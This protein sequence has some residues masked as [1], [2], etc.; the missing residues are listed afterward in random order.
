[1]KQF[2]TREA[3][4]FGKGV[5]ERLLTGAPPSWTVTSC[6]E[7]TRLAFQEAT[8]LRQ[9]GLVEVPARQQKVV[10]Q[11]VQMLHKLCSHRDQVPQVCCNLHSSTE[12]LQE[13]CL[14]AALYMAAISKTPCTTCSS[15]WHMR[16][17]C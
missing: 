11:R 4:H 8:H 3:L 5:C 17:L 6:C 13:A 7:E 2:Y 9:E 14:D 1:M 12:K 15:G 16:F 10:L